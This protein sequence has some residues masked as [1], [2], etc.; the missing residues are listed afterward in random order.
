MEI[1][2]PEEGG[3]PKIGTKIAKA[4]SQKGRHNG[5]IGDIEGIFQACFAEKS[6]L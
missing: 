4:F 1:R 2:A 6:K 5:S 3:L